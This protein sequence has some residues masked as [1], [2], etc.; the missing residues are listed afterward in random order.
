MC[1][2]KIEEL[3]MMEKVSECPILGGSV[4]TLVEY[5]DA[6]VLG[7]NANLEFND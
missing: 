4:W 7:G 5:L 6:R 1:V 3:V 2:G